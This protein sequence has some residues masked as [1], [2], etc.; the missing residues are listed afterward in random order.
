MGDIKQLTPD[1]ALV[2]SLFRYYKDH[3]RKGQIFMDILPI[4]A[5]S[6]ASEIVVVSLFPYVLPKSPSIANVNHSIIGGYT[7]VTG[8]T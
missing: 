2:L 6:D 8:G 4:F 1:C 7:T 5:N 3:P